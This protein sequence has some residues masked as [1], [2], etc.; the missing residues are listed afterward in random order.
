[1]AADIINIFIYINQ[2][3]E[4]IQNINTSNDEVKS[5]KFRLPENDSLQKLRNSINIA[6]SESKT[7]QSLFFSHDYEWKIFTYSDMIEIAEDDDLEDEIESIDSDDESDNDT[8]T[9]LLKLRVVF[10]RSYVIFIKNINC[11]INRHYQIM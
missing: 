11:Y 7:F 9:K 4:A 2:Q 8:S 3:Y 5:I 6:F 1:M 10:C